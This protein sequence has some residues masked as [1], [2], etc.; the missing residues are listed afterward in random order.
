[1]NADAPFSPGQ[2]SGYNQT[3]SATSSSQTVTLTAG[4]GVLR[5]AVTGANPIAFRTGLASA[6]I[7]TAVFA[8]D[9]VMLPGSTE[10]FS[11][12]NQFDTVAV[13]SS[14]TAMA[15]LSRGEGN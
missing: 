14:G 1:M 12:N 7:V 6:G 5:I 10:V 2:G 11:M 8:T 15:Y 9:T 13:I 3:I 4:T